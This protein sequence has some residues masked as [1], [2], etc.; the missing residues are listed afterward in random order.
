[1]PQFRTRA[2]NARGG[3]EYSDL[4]TAGAT[5]QTEPVKMAAP[6]RNLDP[7]QTLYALVINWVALNSPENGNSEITT[8]HL[9][10]FHEEQWKDLYGVGPD[11][12]DTEFVVTSEITRGE[13][14][15]FRVRAANIHGVGEWSDTTQI[16]SA[17]IPY[18]MNPVT[19]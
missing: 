8:Y 14:Y 15:G 5:V 16:K 1:M 4:N 18:K 3:G 12:T 7:Q 11:A 19:T 6:Q 9:Q 17:G 10:W 2:I 13:I